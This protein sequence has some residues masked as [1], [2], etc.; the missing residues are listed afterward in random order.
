MRELPLSLRP[1]DWVRSPRPLPQAALRL[2]CLPY[3]GGDTSLF[4]TWPAALPP[5]LQE[6]I[7]ICAI[8]LPGR[9][10]RLRE[11]PLCTSLQALIELL[12]PYSLQESPLY[13][14]LVDKPFAF[15]GASSFG[16][17][18]CFELAR[19][20]SLRHEREAA[21]LCVAACRAPHLPG[22]YVLDESDQLSETD[23]LQQLQEYG[24]T[25]AYILQ[26]ERL[27]ELARPKLVADSLLCATYA[28]MPD[29]GPDCPILVVGGTDDPIVSMADLAAWQIH[30]RRAFRL[31]M[32]PG[33]HFFVRDA[34]E[35]VRAQLLEYICR[36]LRPH[37]AQ[38]A[39][40]APGTES[41]KQPQE[42]HA[43]A[44]VEG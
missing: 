40:G 38:L 21:A 2:F 4:R 23:L 13:P 14:Y 5:D 44:R 43:S 10:H 31:Y 22:P 35:S 16:G 18:I 9:A 3:G 20:F 37:L 19:A 25:P 34:P 42:I 12:V 24:G 28:Y 26:D 32:L 17:L 7:E 1:S 29:L 33:N 36:P 27:M 39:T 30:T 15:F 6:R 11:R 8:Q 41:Q